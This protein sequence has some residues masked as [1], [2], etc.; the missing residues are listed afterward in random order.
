MALNKAVA[1]NIL[2][3][4]ERVGSALYTLLESNPPSEWIVKEN[5]G[6]RQYDT[7]PIER[8]DYL[9]R[10]IYTQHYLE[11]LEVKPG[12]NFIAVT[13]RVHVLCPD[14]A[15]WKHTDG[16]ASERLK[17]Q[18]SNCL[19]IA[20]ALAQKNACKRLGRIFGRDLNREKATEKVA[21]VEPEEA[22]EVTE[23]S[24]PAFIRIMT[25]AKV[26]KRPQN[27]V[28]AVEKAEGE[29]HLNKG[30]FE[31]IIGFLNKKAD[32]KN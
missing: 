9:L 3:G 5:D 11:V 2:A 24:S 18:E 8:I 27:I 1:G 20:I 7:L 25:Q 23:E 13:V 31:I 4:V 15:K 26:T 14:S 30:E 12:S 32:E 17:G 16:G 29:G 21:I 10:N 19:Q 6:V 22:I 28:K